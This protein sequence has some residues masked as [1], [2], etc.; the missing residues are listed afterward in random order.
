MSSFTDEERA[1]PFWVR[2]RGPFQLVLT[3]PF[4]T[5]PG[6]YRSDWLA[7]DV[8]GPDVEDEARALLEDPRDTI[9]GV[10]VWSCREEQFVFG[11]ATDAGHRGR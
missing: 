8:D 9:T 4:A 1:R 2:H 3:R 10:S 11:Y 7:G 5:K 6:F